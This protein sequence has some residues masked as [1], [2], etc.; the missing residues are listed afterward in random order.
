M[1]FKLLSA[2]SYSVIAL[3]ASVFILGF[4]L[5]LNLG[6]LGNELPVKTVDQFRNIANIMPLVVNLSPDLDAIQARNREIDKE[7]LGF[8]IAKLNITAQLIRDDFG[9]NPAYDLRIILDELDSLCRELSSMVTSEREPD[10]ASTIL[11]LN[12]SEYVY[13]EFRDYILRLN[14]GTLEILG[15]QR[16]AIDRLRRAILVASLIASI[17]AALTMLLLRNRRKLF[18]QLEESREIALAASRAKSE[19]LSNMSHEI[20]TPM[21]AI[22]GLAYLALRTSLTPSQREYLKRIQTSSQ[23]LL[24][25]INDILDFSKIEA[26]K[27][28]IEHIPFELGKVLDNVANLTAEKASEK[29]LELIIETERDVPDRLSGDPLRLGQILVNFTNNAVKF[30]EQGEIHILVSVE[31]EL[32]HDVI[33]RFQVK[34]TGIGMTPE[35]I[36]KIFRSFQ[37]ADSTITRRYGGTGLG[38][39]ISRKLAEMMGG[40]VGVESEFGVGSTFWCTARFGKVPG[41]KEPPLFPG[42]LRSR[43]IL[44]VDDNEHARAVMLDMLRSMEFLVSEAP[45]GKA[46]LELVEKASCEGTAFDVIFLDWKMDGMNGIETAERIRSLGLVPEPNLV[47]VTAYGREEVIQ[48][49]EVLGI[50]DVLIKPLSPSVLLDSV[51]HVLHPAGPGTVEEPEPGIRDAAVLHGELSGARILVAEDSEINREVAR[52][53]LE[54][55]GC[56][57]RLAN[58]GAEAVKALREAAFDI[59]L[60]DV[61]MPVMDGCEAAVLIRKIPGC[62]DLPVIAMTA[63]ALREDQ[64]R[65]IEA[66]MNDFVSKPFNPDALFETLRKYYPGNGN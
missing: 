28:S 59:V 1:K 52:E 17:A 57:V 50:R 23:H 31:Q 30:T 54:S 55:A 13:A 38:L 15:K 65:C 25:I 58:D 9:G 60:M 43:R 66:G 33:L 61:Q 42:D 48:E 4:L 26:G 10:P 7:R 11:F 62:Q 5:F 29:G 32:E 51:M 64:D 20:R 41:R 37:Q 39:A 14:N 49:A 6:K 18:A 34:D 45:S 53:I 35:Q 44:V 3:S 2:L 46:A 27:L 21:N 22:I 16:L 40:D 12:R 56:R 24:G 63:S 47:I 8:D 36:S 19:F